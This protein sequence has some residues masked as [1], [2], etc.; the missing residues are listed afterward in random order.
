VINGKKGVVL[1]NTCSCQRKT[2]QIVSMEVTT[3]DL[4]NGKMLK[5]LVNHMTTSLASFPYATESKIEVID[6]D[7]YDSKDNFRYVKRISLLSS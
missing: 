2:K 5:P 3:E 1:S 4:T 7:S 6:D